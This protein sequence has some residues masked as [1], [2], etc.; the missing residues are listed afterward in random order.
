[1]FEAQ[2]I[3]VYPSAPP[4]YPQQ[5]Q[6]GTARTLSPFPHKWTAQEV[7]N[8]KLL[9]R[10]PRKTTFA[11]GLKR[12]LDIGFAALLLTAFSPVMLLIAVALFLENRGPIFYV[13]ERV[14]RNGRRFSILKFRTMVVNA[15]Q[16]LTTH[17]T[18]D[19][20]ARQEWDAHFKLKQDPRIT[21]LGRFLRQTS[22]DELPQFVNVILGE[23]S[24]VGPRPLPA[25]HHDKL[26]PVFKRI[27]E[28]VRPGISG[29]WQISSRSEGDLRSFEFF[30][31]YYVTNW[32]LR[33]D[34]T[35][36]LKTPFAILSRKG[37]Y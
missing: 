13:Q 24:L 27:R 26:S 8:A 30:D 23:M 19:K 37:A 20:A 2:I 33:M 25:Y 31:A 28:H 3:P 35:I 18:Q 29:L 4:T 16:V 34:L 14:G 5:R 17:L 12:L 6:Q 10:L 15:E 7:K 21:R 9:T 1:M 32:S 36:M 11:R 22:L